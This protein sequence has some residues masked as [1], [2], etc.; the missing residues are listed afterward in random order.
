MEANWMYDHFTGQMV[1][2]ENVGIYV[3]Y[4]EI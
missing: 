3:E 2:I 1:S 4:E